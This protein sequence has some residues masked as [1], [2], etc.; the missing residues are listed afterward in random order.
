MWESVERLVDSGKGWFVL[1]II[2]LM[3]F[4]IRQGYMKVRT[5]KILLGRDSGDKERLLIKKQIDFAHGACMAF[6]KRIPRFEGYNP[7]IGKYIAELAFD[8]IV[9]WITVNHIQDNEDYIEVKQGIIWDIVVTEAI[10]EHIKSEKVRKI[11]Y[12]HTEDI[13]KKLVQIRENDKEGK[14]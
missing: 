10:N 7:Y 9:N 6:E 8:E 5:E 1:I 4:A 2:L 14:K 13:I 3:I 12:Q 11:V